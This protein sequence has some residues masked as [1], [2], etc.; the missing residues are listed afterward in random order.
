MRASKGYALYLY[1]ASGKVLY[2]TPG[3]VLYYIY[4]GQGPALCPSG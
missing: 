2:Y 3:K 4:P 1:Y